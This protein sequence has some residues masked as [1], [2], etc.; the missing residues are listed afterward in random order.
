[1]AAAA[2]ASASRTFLYSQQ[3]LFLHPFCIPSRHIAALSGRR[4]AVSPPIIRCL[5]STSVPQNQEKAVPRPNVVQ[6]LEERGLIESVTDN[7]RS[8]CCNSTLKVYCG[9]DPTAESLHLGNLLGIIVLSWFQRCGHKVVALIG[10]ATARVGDPSGKS[11]ERP[12]LDSQTLEKNSI[13]IT[14]TVARILAASSAGDDDSFLILNNYDWWKEVRLLD[15]LKQVGRYARVGTMMAKESVKKRLESEQG[16][17]YT[18]FTYQLLQGYDFLHLFRDAGV[19]V[20]IGGSDQW[21][22]ITAGTELIRKI[23]QLQADG[24]ADGP[25]GLTFPLLLKSDG[26]KFGKSEDG[27]VW[28]SPSMFSPYKFYQYFFSVP[29]ADV[30]RFLKILTFLDTEEITS[31]ERD[32]K[33]PG[34]VPNTAQRRLA[35]EVTLFVHGEDGLNEAIK[36]TQ[37][38]KPGADTKLDWKT[39]EGIAENV[40]SCSFAYDE[41]VNVPLV[42]LS[43]S[44][45]LVD[46]KSAARRLLKQG[47]LY[48]NNCR[49][50]NESKRIESQDIIDGKVL[51]LSAGKKNKACLFF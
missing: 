48:M 37:A 46:T 43:V 28:L 2:A 35:E 47:G 13:G 16:M 17:S 10:G 11:L 23:L 34:Y 42:D 7:L 22:N 51:L 31:L 18:E 5:H 44:S 6:V 26:T 8:A 49:V 40:P 30:V 36:A 12:E 32:M 19:N 3:R 20:Q 14:D 38:L 39:I 24:S 15:F 29:D 33:S 41:V 50:D 9:F 27:A 1:M 25:H 45:G 21:G 4:T